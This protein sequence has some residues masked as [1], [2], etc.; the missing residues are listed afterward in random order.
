MKKLH[1][2]VNAKIVFRVGN[3]LL[4]FRSRDGGHYL[5]GGH[6]DHGEHPLDAL[7]RELVEEMGYELPG[8]PVVLGAWTSVNDAE[9]LH[10]ITI[11]YLLD[12]PSKPDFHWVATDSSEG[13]EAFVW[14]PADRID[15]YAAKPKFRRLL[16]RAAEHS[17][18]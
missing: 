15:E 4:T 18:S 11:V 6:L 14:I 16:H 9:D 3:E 12:L 5:P 7:K 8:E 1:T 13:F 2:F 10:R 17:H